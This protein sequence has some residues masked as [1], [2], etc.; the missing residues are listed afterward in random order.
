MLIR[1]TLTKLPK[2]TAHQGLYL[3]P[4]CIQDIPD[5]LE[6]YIPSKAR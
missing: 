2:S 4:V 6:V 3:S 1:L 5:Q